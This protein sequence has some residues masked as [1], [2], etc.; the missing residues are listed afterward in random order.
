[1]M[2]AAA[3]AAAAAA[4]GDDAGCGG[5]RKKEEEGQGWE[6]RESRV[7]FLA[8]ISQPHTIPTAL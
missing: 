7:A 4:T 8:C 2:L 6:T 3:A 1:M 5:L